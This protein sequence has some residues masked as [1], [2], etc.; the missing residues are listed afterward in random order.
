MIKEHIINRIQHHLAFEPTTTQRQAIAQIAGFMESVSYKPLFLLRG[1]AGTGKTSLVAAFVKA[2]DEMGIKAALLAPTGRAAKVLSGYVGQPAYTIHK[3][4]YRQASS[5]DGFGGFNLNFNAQKDTIFIVDEASMVSNEAFGQTAFGSGR[6]LDDLIRFVYEADNCRLMLI[7]DTA[8]L[9]PVGLSVSPALDEQNLL[10]YGVELWQET[11]TDVVRQEAD[12]GILTNATSLRQL[13]D[14]ES[15]IDNF[16]KLNTDS[17]PDIIRLP[18]NELME[19][20]N[21][22]Y[23]E[24]GLE[25]TLVVC[26][27]NKRANLYNK[28]IRNSILFREEELSAGDY[29]LVMKNNY[30]WLKN[31]EAINF[32]ANGDIARITRVKKI[33]ELY[34]YRFAD[35]SCALTD[36]QSMELDVRILLDSLHAEGPGLTLQE[37]ETFFNKILEDYQ[38]VTPAK[39][40]FDQAREDDFYN[41]LQVKFAYAMTCHKSQGGQWKAVFIDLGYFTEEFLSRELVRWLY[42]AVTRATHRLYLVNFPKEFFA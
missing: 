26:R 1:F 25:E 28:G 7:G 40:Q 38:D 6:L 19:E 16:P 23:G 32:I 31:H 18:G 10:G 24:F 34:G 3:K 17:F 39:K 8:Q 15:T 14:Q 30:H 42:T 5:K 33:Y 29:L 13:L 21:R 20:L 41:A 11:L 35:L 37:Q 9:P 12:S 27:T 2:I 36:Y 22:C 4:I